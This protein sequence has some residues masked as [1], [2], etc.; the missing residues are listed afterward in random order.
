MLRPGEVTPND[1][2]RATLLRIAALQ[3]EADLVVL[4]LHVLSREYT[5]LY[6]G[7]DG[8]VGTAGGAELIRCV[9]EFTLMLNFPRSRA[10]IA[11]VSAAKLSQVE[12]QAI[13]DVSRLMESDLTQSPDP[14][15]RGGPCDRCHAAVP[16]G[17]YLDVGDWICGIHE[18]FGVGDC[19]L[20]ERGDAGGQRVDNPWRADSIGGGRGR[21]HESVGGRCPVDPG[22]TGTGYERGRPTLR[23]RST[24]RATGRNP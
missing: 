14:C 9:S 10:Y 2:E 17:R 16:A 20:V 6:V 8:A 19:P 15:L 24:S 13:L 1:L 5:G 3:P 23:L 12:S 18:P 21:I 4:D 11:R 7:C 22:S